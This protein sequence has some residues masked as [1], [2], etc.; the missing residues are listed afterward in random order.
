MDLKK[1][2]GVLSK[3]TFELSVNAWDEDGLLSLLSDLTQT[4]GRTQRTT[5]NTEGEVT[6]LR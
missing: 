1:E 3:K 4:L 2:Y 5:A 6:C